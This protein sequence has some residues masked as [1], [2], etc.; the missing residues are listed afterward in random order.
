MQRRMLF[1]HAGP[2][3][4][5]QRRLVHGSSN[6]PRTINQLV[7]ENENTHDTRRSPDTR[8]MLHAHE[9]ELGLGVNGAC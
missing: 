4:E 3:R 7:N 6:E 1:I 2:V 9:R 8:E 5:Q